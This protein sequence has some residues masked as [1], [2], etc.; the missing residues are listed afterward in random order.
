MD[1]TN[2]AVMLAVPMVLAVL[3]GAVE[4]FNLRHMMES[5]K[6][7]NEY[8][9]ALEAATLEQVQNYSL[10]VEQL[11]M[12]SSILERKLSLVNESTRAE[13]SKIRLH[14]SSLLAT[15]NGILNPDGS[16]ATVETVEKNLGLDSCVKKSETC[17]TTN[18]YKNKTLNVSF[19]EC[20][21]ALPQPTLDGEIVGGTSSSGLLLGRVVHRDC[22]M[23]TP[24]GPGGG[25]NTFESI[26]SSGTSLVLRDQNWYCRCYGMHNSTANV[27][28]FSCVL[29]VTFCNEGASLV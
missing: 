26:P 23:E 28:P 1:R 7:V 14:L 9:E 11:L 2:I 6:R 19:S 13:V 15:M 21:T 27:R 18:Q 24:P 25:I 20:L 4:V 22:R 29:T 12:E 3:L 5:C 16:N 10:V 8:Q 17:F